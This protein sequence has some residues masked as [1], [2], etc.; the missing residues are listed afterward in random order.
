MAAESG[1]KG[2]EKPKLH[3]RNKHKSRYNF[4]QLISTCPE[5]KDYVS[6]NKFGDLSI[7]FKNPEA[8]KLLNK[9]LLKHFYH[10]NYWEIPAGYLCPPI[11]GRADYLHYVADVLAED[12]GGTIP[13]VITLLDIGIGANSIYPLIGHK[14]YGWNFVGSD[15]DATAIS[16]AQN[17]INRNQLQDNITL[18][19]QN[20]KGSTFKGIIKQD[21]FFHVTVCNPPFHSSL[22]ETMSGIK[23]KWK[24]LGEKKAN[25]AT[26][27]FGGQNNELWCQGGEQQFVINMIKESRLFAKNC[28]WFTSL[29]SK[30]ESLKACYKTLEQVDCAEVKTI[31]MAQG[32]KASRILAWTFLEKNERAG[33][34]KNR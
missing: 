4:P 22:E 18:R 10:I 34:F 20:T 16:S 15:I 2:E 26:M 9:A 29:I 25:Q 17:I 3:V 8:V 1:L 13:A 31:N 30:K 33:T 21:D 27:N 6:L 7:D 12:N 32:Q 24:N 19:K 23:R 28:L 11:P 14:E 5:L